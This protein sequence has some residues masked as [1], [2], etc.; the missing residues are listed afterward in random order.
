MDKRNKKYQTVNQQKRKQSQNRK[1]KSIKLRA[2][3]LKRSIKP[4]NFWPDLGNKERRCR[5]EYQE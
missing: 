5:L 1:R 3:S 4:I 2:S